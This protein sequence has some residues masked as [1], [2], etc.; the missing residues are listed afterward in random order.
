MQANLAVPLGCGA[1]QL[2][3]FLLCNYVEASGK[4]KYPEATAAAAV[5]L[6]NLGWK[7]LG[8]RGERENTSCFMSSAVVNSGTLVCNFLR[9]A[10]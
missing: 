3:N 6:G 9:V 7:T 5:H 4:T 10:G 8:G 2:K 1:D